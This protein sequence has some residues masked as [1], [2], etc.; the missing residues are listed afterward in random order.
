MTQK[1]VGLGRRLFCFRPY[2]ERTLLRLVCVMRPVFLSAL[3]LLAGVAAPHAWAAPAS[4]GAQ[5]F[6]GRVY[7]VDTVFNNIDVI[8]PDRKRTLWADASTRVRVHGQR[9]QLID[10][11]MGDEVKGT[12]VAGPKGALRL[13]RIDDP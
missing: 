8:M 4:S 7:Q 1:A 12:Y 5:P 11:A 2:L 10:I 6:H 13:V 9:A 3:L